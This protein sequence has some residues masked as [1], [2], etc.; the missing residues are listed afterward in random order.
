[1]NTYILG[2]NNEVVP[3]PFDKWIEWEKKNPDRR[4]ISRNRVFIGD[5][6]ILVSTVFLGLD[7]SR[8][9]GPPLVFET[10]VFGGINSDW[11]DRYTNYRDACEGHLKVLEAVINNEELTYS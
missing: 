8:N 6:E 2:S 7:H 10:M 11:Q 4:I 5:E 1:M 9:G 3:V